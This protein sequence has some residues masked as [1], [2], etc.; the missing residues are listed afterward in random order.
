MG[1]R[2]KGRASVLSI[3]QIA[4]LCLP[5]HCFTYLRKVLA[6]VQ[7]VARDGRRGAGVSEAPNSF[8]GASVLLPSALRRP[9]RGT[10][11]I[12]CPIVSASSRATCSGTQIPRIA[13]LSPGVDEQRGIST[14]QPRSALPIESCAIVTPV[15]PTI[16]KHAR[17]KSGCVASMLS[18][19]AVGM[20]KMVRNDEGQYCAGQGE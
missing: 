7:V 11:A 10:H 5:K 9:R 18:K 16:W 19:D 6:V 4:S 1:W 15:S 12:V 17:R 13:L 8:T 14:Y 2:R 3:R 20:S